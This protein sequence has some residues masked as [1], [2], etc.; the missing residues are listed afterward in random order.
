VFKKVPSAEA[1]SVIVGSHFPALTCRAIYIPP[2]R[3]WSWSFPGPRPNV[4]FKGSVITR[5]YISKNAES[6]LPTEALVH[7]ILR[8][9]AIQKV[10]SLFVA[11]PVSDSIQRS[12]LGQTSADVVRGLIR[13]LRQSFNF[14]VNLFVTDLNI[15]G[16]SDFLEQ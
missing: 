7:P 15:F 10:E 11:D 12:I 4:G 9:L 14:P 16:I 3:G 8:G 6:R 2:L 13:L 1:D 5:D